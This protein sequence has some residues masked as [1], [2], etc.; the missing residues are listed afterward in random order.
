[1]VLRNLDARFKVQ[2]SPL[3]LRLILMTLQ[4]PYFA[5]HCMQLVRKTNVY[6]MVP[7]AA[8]HITISI[9]ILFIPQYQTKQLHKLL[10]NLKSAV[11]KFKCRK[12]KVE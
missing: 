1:M 8:L 4:R 7:T 2:S 6:G 5:L 10:I 11:Y 3:L 9:D 12:R